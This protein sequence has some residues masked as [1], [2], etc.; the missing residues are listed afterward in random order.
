MLHRKIL[1]AIVIEPVQGEVR[2]ISSFMQ[3]YNAR[4]RRARDIRL[5][6]DEVL[7]RAGV[8]TMEMALRRIHTLRKGG[9]GLWRASLARED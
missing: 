3:R 1:A 5:I 6:A 9:G 7:Q 4:C 8:G 2:R